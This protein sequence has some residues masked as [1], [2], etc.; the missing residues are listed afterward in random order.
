M[1]QCP[2]SLIQHLFDKK[3]T[4]LLDPIQLDITPDS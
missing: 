4:R 2:N 1:I 3:K